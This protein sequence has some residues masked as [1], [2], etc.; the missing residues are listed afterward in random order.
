MKAMRCLRI[1][2][3]PACGLEEIR[4]LLKLR[5]RSGLVID[6]AICKCADELFVQDH[7]VIVDDNPTHGWWFQAP[8]EASSISVG[9]AEL[10][11]V[12]DGEVAGFA[13]EVEEP[14]EGDV[15]EVSGAAGGV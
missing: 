7:P 1:I 11:V 9:D 12:V 5:D 6:G 13:P 14:A 4:D 2:T 15:E 10:D 3:W 8:E